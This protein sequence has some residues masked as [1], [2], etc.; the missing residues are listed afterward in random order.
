MSE[1]TTRPALSVVLLCAGPSRHVRIALDRLARQTAA[2]RMELVLVVPA[3]EVAA[4]AEGHLAHF[5]GHQIVVAGPFRSDSLGKARGVQA[6]TAP[7]VAFCEDHSYPARDWA[8]TLIRRHDELD[9][10]VIGPIV[11]NANP[12]STASRGC[13]LVFY[14]PFSYPRPSQE[15]AD[16]P[17]NNAAYRTELLLALG[18]RL[19]GAMAAESITHA[20]WTRQGKKLCQAA[21]CHTW[22]MQPSR[23]W[24]AMTEYFFSS[25]LFAYYR[26]KNWSDARRWLQIVLS[27]TLPWLRAWRAFRDG[28][29]AGMPRADILTSLG[30]AF[31]ILCAGTAGEVLGYALGPGNAEELLLRY[32][33]SREEVYSDGDLAV[34]ERS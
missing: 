10:A 17:S 26:G 2:R 1:T 20:E 24:P 5:C 12:A 28:R 31:A 13:F 29:R 19:A 16:L 32:G 34:V 25:R 8:E 21:D 9:W 33:P 30:A 14:G 7:L 4:V 23:L 22:H 18:E 6:A 15:V 11:H 27:P 3:R